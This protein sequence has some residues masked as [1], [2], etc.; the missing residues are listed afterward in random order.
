MIDL[1][2]ASLAVCLFLAACGDKEREVQRQRYDEYSRELQAHQ[3][4]TPEQLAGV[5]VLD[6]LVTLYSDPYDHRHDSALHKDYNDSSVFLVF[7][8]GKYARSV[9]SNNCPASA[10]SGDWLVDLAALKVT[11]V[12]PK[13][14]SAPEVPPATVW[15]LNANVTV[16]R[17]FAAVTE[18]KSDKLAPFELEEDL[19]KTALAFREN[20]KREAFEKTYV[21]KMGEADGKRTLE[22]AHK[23]TSLT[24]GIHTVVERYHALSEDELKRRFE[25]RIKTNYPC[26]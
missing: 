13:A 10:T 15:T 21:Y 9:L 4:V 26:P 3:T 5:W 24:T 14:P 25:E 23:N 18:K 1:L 22:L 12:D 19:L 7:S 16:P 8:Q 17:L 20:R 2:R 11:V 6:R